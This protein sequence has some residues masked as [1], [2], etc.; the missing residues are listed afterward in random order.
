MVVNLHLQVQSVDITTKV[1]S[2]NIVHGKLYS[3][4]HYQQ[5]FSY[6]EV[7][8]FIDGGSRITR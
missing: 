2:S 6:M 5:Y 7:I 8:S 3:I 1:V 4:Q